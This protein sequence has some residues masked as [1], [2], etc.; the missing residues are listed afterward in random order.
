MNSGLDDS[1]GDDVSPANLKYIADAGTRW[2]YHNVYVK[3]QDVV[4]AASNQTWNSYFNTK[5]KEK[6]GMTVV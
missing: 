6:I 3:M 5:L 4:A 2:G 1:T